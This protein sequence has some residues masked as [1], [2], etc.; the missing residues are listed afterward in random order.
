MRTRVWAWLLSV[1][2]LVAVVALEVVLLRDDIAADVHLLLE[3][4]RSGSTA[5]TVHAS[6][7]AFR[8]PA[9]AAGCRS[10]GGD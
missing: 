5:S 3:A 1:A 6:P 10:R 9:G 8:R 4:G 2:V 7:T